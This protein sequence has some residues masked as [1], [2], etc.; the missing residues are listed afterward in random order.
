MDLWNWNEHI[1]FNDD[2]TFASFIKENMEYKF[3]L[4]KTRYRCT[5]TNI[6]TN[7]IEA[8]FTDHRGYISPG[9]A[10]LNTFIREYKNSKYQYVN[11]EL[12]LTTTEQI[13]PY[14]KKIKKEEKQS[15]KFLTLDIETQ[16]V[17]YTL[18]RKGK[19][20]TDLVQTIVCITI[21]SGN[22]LSKSFFIT[23]YSASSIPAEAMVKDCIEFIL[24]NYKSYK[25]YI[26]N[27]SGFDGIYLMNTIASYGDDAKV[28]MRDDNLITISIRKQV[29]SNKRTGQPIY[30]SFTFRDSL[31]LLPFS[32]DKL[33]K[34]FG[35]GKK[36]EF[37]F[38]TFNQSNISD[39]KVRDE[40][41]SYNLSDCVLLYN[42]ISKFATLIYELFQIDIHKYPTLTSISFAIYLKCFMAKENIS[43]TSLDMYNKIK[44]GYIGGAVD[45]YRTKGKNVFYY[46]VNS[47]YPSVMK[48]NQYPVGKSIYF[49]G[50]KPLHQIFGLVYCKVTAPDNIFAPILL[51]RKGE[52]TIAPTG[53]WTG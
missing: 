18:L 37:D 6:N 48:F 12:V 25:V 43:I 51:T 41:L 15:N 23:D 14:I 24:D 29:G 49:R 28:I 4:Y 36:I 17:P 35:V 42:V 47:L 44:S 26:H 30:N 19:P 50:E 22:D 39:P 34:S 11:G 13:N 20:A 53:S 45:V 27:L 38:N 5:I 52:S 8:I 16:G 40:L 3:N 21:Y 7:K 2:Y 46:D 10:E 32:L 31:L 9:A 1:T 33:G